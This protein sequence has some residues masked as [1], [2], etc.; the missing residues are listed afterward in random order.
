AHADRDPRVFAAPHTFDIT[1]AP[2]P[3]LAFGHGPHRCV[4]AGLA[5]LELRTAFLALARRHPDL[6]IARPVTGLPFL[7]GSLIGGVAHLPVTFP[8]TARAR[9]SS[10]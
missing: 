3:I 4:G 5:L 1:R 2:G 7:N 9:T 8:G 6:T 10:G